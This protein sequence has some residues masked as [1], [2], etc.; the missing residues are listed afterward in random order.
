MIYLLNEGG[1]S[2]DYSSQLFAFLVLLAFGGGEVVY[3]IYKL[4]K[5]RDKSLRWS[6]LVFTLFT[7]I[8][9][10]NSFFALLLLI[11]VFMLMAMVALPIALIYIG[12]EIYVKFK[13]VKA[14]EVAVNFKEGIRLVLEGLFGWLPWVVVKKNR[15]N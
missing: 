1:F 15:L 5:T 2:G 14:S 4:G 9:F 12:F 7:L 13:S 11:I 3:L 6:L 8:N 10:V